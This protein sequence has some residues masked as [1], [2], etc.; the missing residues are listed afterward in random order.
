MNPL[1]Y[2]IQETAPIAD[3]GEIK[4]PTKEEKKKF[5]QNIYLIDSEVLGSSI[6]HCALL[7]CIRQESQCDQNIWI[8]HVMTSHLAPT[9]K[10]TRQPFLPRLGQCSS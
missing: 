3:L 4:E 7:R 6:D 1:R 10:H 5:S 9:H 8:P 2:P